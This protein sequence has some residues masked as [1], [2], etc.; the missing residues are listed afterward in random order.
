MDRLPETEHPGLEQFQ[1]YSRVEILALLRE[2][3]ERRILVTIYFRG[4]ERFVL[5]TVLGVNPEFEEIVFD[6]SADPRDTEELLRS[7]TLVMVAFLDEV[8]VQFRAGRAERCTHEDGVAL[9]VRVP[10][11]VL[12]LQ[13]REFYR[14]ATPMTRPL[15]VTVP[16]TEPS[17]APLRLRVADLSCGGVGVVGE[18]PLLGLEPGA[19]LRHCRL[20]LPGVGV[21]D[22]SLEVRHIAQPRGGAAATQTRWGMRFVN[23][24]PGSLT[25]LQRY[26]NKLERERRA[27]K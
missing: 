22:A 17:A 8:K 3:A 9:R 6:A 27:R 21:I 12:R 2:I 7:G 16:P 11:S 25:L 5:T 20:E 14:V 10:D 24:A 18:S 4:G 15:V 19:V 1:L 23:L 13:R 26:I